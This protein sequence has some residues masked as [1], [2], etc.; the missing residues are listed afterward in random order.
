MRGKRAVC[1]N[2]MICPPK[3]FIHD[4]ILQRAVG[5]EVLIIVDADDDGGG[6]RYGRQENEKKRDG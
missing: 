4:G 6:E 5:G 3:W 2:H 1:C